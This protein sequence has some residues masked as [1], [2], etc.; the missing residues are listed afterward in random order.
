MTMQPDSVSN[1]AHI[2]Y[3]LSEF[4]DETEYENEQELKN[5]FGTDFRY[6][7]LRAPFEDAGP[8]VAKKRTH[9]L[10]YEFRFAPLKAGEAVTFNLYYGAASTQSMALNEMEAVGA[11][12]YAFAWD[13]PPDT[14]NNGTEFV[15]VGADFPEC[16]AN[17]DSST[18]MIGI[19]GVKY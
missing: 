14:P 8:F 18:F 13:L 4:Y 16:A 12:S 2:E 3:A 7:M 17:H 11:E 10:Y 9:M 15:K 6:D 1:T 5:E 19:T